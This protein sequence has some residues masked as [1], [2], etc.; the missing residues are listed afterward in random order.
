MV[1]R[2]KKP[3]R[4]RRVVDHM[5]WDPELAKL[6]LVPESWTVPAL[7]KVIHGKAGGTFSAVFIDEKGGRAEAYARVRFT[8]AGG[9]RVV[10][11]GLRQS[12]RFGVKSGAK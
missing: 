5:P 6:F 2:R 1:V 11:Q 8:K 3:T 4:A 12:F 9:A 10:E 7:I